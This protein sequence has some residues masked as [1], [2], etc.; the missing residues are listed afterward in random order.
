[1]SSRK[2]THFLLQQFLIHKYILE[3]SVRDIEEIQK[4]YYDYAFGR[5]SA[6]VRV[7][8]ALKYIKD[9][10]LNK[11]SIEIDVSLTDNLLFL[12]S[13]ISTPNHFSNNQINLFSK[14]EY[15][16]NSEDVKNRHPLFLCNHWKL[17]FYFF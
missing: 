4:V 8:S 13:N 2:A 16:R 17:L 15:I 3:Y 5:A 6:D 10:L 11:Y 7:E 12:F 1:M 14:F 9:Y